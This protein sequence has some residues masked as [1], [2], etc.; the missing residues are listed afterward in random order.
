MADNE[1]AVRSCSSKDFSLL[2]CVRL[3]LQLRALANGRPPANPGNTLRGAFGAALRAISCIDSRRQCRYCPHRHECAYLYLFETPLPPH[4]ARLRTIDHLPHPFVLRPWNRPLSDIARGE[5]LAPEMI[6]VGK[7][8][9]FI[10]YIAIALEQMAARGLGKERLPFRFLGIEQLHLQHDIVQR[11]L[12]DKMRPVNEPLLESLALA[13][14]D[15][16][17]SSVSIH[18][19]TPA[20]IVSEGRPLQYMEFQPLVRALLRRSSSLAYFHCG[21]PLELDFQEMIERARDIQTV[22]ED[23]SFI[24]GSRFSRRQGARV[25]QTGLIGNITFQ[26]QALSEFIPLLALGEI[27]HVGKGTVFGMGRYRM[28]Q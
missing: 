22:E 20:H 25:P 27:I 1:I 3:R 8:V 24:T 2:R 17:Y 6:L 7:A 9:D 16:S 18:F 11:T 19:L 21:S 14:V 23:L 12:F 15:S 5:I 26:G 13:P 28:N 4:A 10:A